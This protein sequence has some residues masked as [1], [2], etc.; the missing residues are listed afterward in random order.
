MFAEEGTAE[1]NVG[2]RKGGATW[3]KGKYATKKYR[4]YERTGHSTGRMKKYGFIERTEQTET[5][6]V[7]ARIFSDF[8]KNVQRAAENI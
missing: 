7:E 5:A 2:K 4:R 8:E 6:G 3:A 1:R